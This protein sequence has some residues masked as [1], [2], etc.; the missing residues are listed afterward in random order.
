MLSE[1]DFYCESKPIPLFSER[2]TNQKILNQIKN[3][4]K[5]FEK[6]QSYPSDH[7]LT[8]SGEGLY[9]F[10]LVG[11]KL[12]DV[13]FH[14]NVLRDAAFDNCVG[15]NLSFLKCSMNHAKFT[16]CQV[17][18]GNFVDCS[19]VRASFSGIFKHIHFIRCYMNQADL[20][21][22]KFIKCNFGNTDFT[23]AKL[24]LYPADWAG[25]TLPSGLKVS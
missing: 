23:G 16:N 9:G 19:F 21:G 4:Q 12:H 18:Y 14:A 5:R 25:S 2:W 8:V 10:N 15:S 22:A 11:M 3:R 7:I 24:S 17:T 20:T 13:R 6:G 1:S